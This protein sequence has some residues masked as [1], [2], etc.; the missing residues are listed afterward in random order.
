MLETFT[1]RPSFFFPYFW[2]VS[3]LFFFFFF[4][5]LLYIFIAS[6]RK[7]HWRPSLTAALPTTPDV[8]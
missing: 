4:F 7:R 3:P 2:V 6:K 5:R 1:S 8:K